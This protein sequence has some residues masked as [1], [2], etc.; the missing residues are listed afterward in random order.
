MNRMIFGLLEEDE[1]VFIARKP[2]LPSVLISHYCPFMR[3]DI[4]LNLQFLLIYNKIQTSATLNSRLLGLALT[5]DHHIPHSY[6]YR[7]ASNLQ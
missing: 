2:I 5:W 3:I 4:F 1:F 7:Q 6:G